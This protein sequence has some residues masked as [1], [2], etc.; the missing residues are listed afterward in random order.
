MPLRPERMPLRLGLGL[1]NNLI[2]IPNLQRPTIVLYYIYN[3]QAIK[4]KVLKIITIR[5][6]YDI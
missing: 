3:I 1:V 4:L 5:L 2:E 6:Y